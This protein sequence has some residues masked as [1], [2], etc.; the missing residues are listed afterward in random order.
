MAKGTRVITT[1]LGEVNYF[2]RTIVY[3]GIVI[4]VG[5]AG[6]EGRRLLHQDDE[7][8]QAKDEKIALLDRQQKETAAA[9]AA[10]EIEVAAQA[11]KITDLEKEVLRHKT[12]LRFLK[13]DHR[14]ARIE[15]LDQTIA[16]DESKTPLTRVRFT[17]IDERDQP[18]APPV[19]ATVKGGELY[20]D[21]QVIHF[22]DELIEQ[23]DELRGRAIC[24]FR[25]MYGDRQSPHD[26]V[27]LDHP[28]E[29]PADV[30]DFE[31]NLWQQFWEIA[32]DHKLA[33][34][35]GVRSAN[36]GGPSILMRPGA[37]YRVQLRSTGELNITPEK[38]MIE[39]Q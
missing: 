6:Y 13:M 7:L 36:G 28:P 27:S 11:V 12:A 38:I 26:G 16:D 17:E 9:L 31:K 23:G 19:E 20:L 15:V 2:M 33:E 4:I 30:T 8:M 37:R 32:N 18:I 22:K 5:I 29:S 14:V 34:L 3:G 1:K 35:E 25:R 10:K 24:R 21:A 39:G